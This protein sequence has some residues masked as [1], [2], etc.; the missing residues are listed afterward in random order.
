MENQAV[1]DWQGRTYVLA[2]VGI[3]VCHSLSEQLHRKH[4]DMTKVKTKVA[5]TGML[6]KKVNGT[7]CPA[8]VTSQVFSTKKVLIYTCQIVVY[9]LNAPL[10][11]GQ[12]FLLCIRGH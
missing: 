11:S 6:Y 9:H 7:S 1:F 5:L 4:R 10:L 2:L 8:H 3:V 12:F